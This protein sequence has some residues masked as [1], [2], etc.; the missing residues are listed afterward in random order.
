MSLFCHLEGTPFKIKY[1]KRITKISSANEKAI[2]PFHCGMRKTMYISSPLVAHPTGATSSNF[3]TSA[4]SILSDMVDTGK[5]Q[6]S[7][8]KR[9]GLQIS[10]KQSQRNFSKNMEEENFREKPSK[11]SVSFCQKI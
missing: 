10:R 8:S 6:D 2:P 7:R 9:V 4:R 3:S 11:W 1:E 5:L